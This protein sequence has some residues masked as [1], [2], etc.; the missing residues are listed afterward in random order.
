MRI[1]INTKLEYQF[2]NNEIYEEK[3]KIIKKTENIFDKINFCGLEIRA[4]TIPSEKNLAYTIIGYIYN[5]G[6]YLKIEF[7]FCNNG[8]F[9]KSDYTEIQVLINRKNKREFYRTGTSSL[10]NYLYGN[11]VLSGNYPKFELEN[12]IAFIKLILFN[13]ENDITEN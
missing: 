6:N 10:F 13:I 12:A 2:D 5:E 7:E 9:L 11:N 4:R 1:E 8:L 3:I